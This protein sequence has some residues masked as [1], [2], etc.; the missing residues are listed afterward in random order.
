MTE[1]G[2]RIKQKLHE[3]MS[4]KY[5]NLAHYSAKKKVQLAKKLTEKQKTQLLSSKKVISKKAEFFD[6]QLNLWNNKFPNFKLSALQFKEL[7]GLENEK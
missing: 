1:K 6:G 7:L 2:L 4:K 5:K 3:K